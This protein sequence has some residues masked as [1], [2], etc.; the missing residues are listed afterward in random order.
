MFFIYL[1]AQPLYVFGITLCFSND[2]NKKKKMISDFPH[3]VTGS[4]TFFVNTCFIYFRLDSVNQS[5]VG[6]VSIRVKALPQEGLTIFKN[7]NNWM[8]D[9]RWLRIS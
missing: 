7:V 3:I 6:I 8:S 4:E 1:V 5:P 2:L 9:S